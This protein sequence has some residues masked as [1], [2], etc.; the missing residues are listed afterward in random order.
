MKRRRCA[1]PLLL[2]SKSH[3]TWPQTLWGEGGQRLPEPQSPVFRSERSTCYG[4]SP[5][6]VIEEIDFQFPPL[7]PQFSP[8][9]PPPHNVQRHCPIAPRKEEKSLTKEIPDERSRGTHD[10]GFEDV[11]SSV[12]GK[13]CS[14]RTESVQVTRQL[15]SSDVLPPPLAPPAGVHSSCLSAGVSK[16]S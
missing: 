3:H 7:C 1:W 12:K 10:P 2:P 9:P 11:R 16:I 14:G 6:F 15:S 5:A 4:S 8:H 13:S